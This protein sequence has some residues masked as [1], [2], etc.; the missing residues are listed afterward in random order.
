MVRAEPGGA[1]SVAGDLGD[2][3]MLEVFVPQKARAIRKFKRLALLGAG[4]G[5]LGLAGLGWFLW[6]LFT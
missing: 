5:L 2:F 6:V 1:E 4:A 3:G